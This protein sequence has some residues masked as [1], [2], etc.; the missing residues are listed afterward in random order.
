MLRALV[1]DRNLFN[2]CP[3]IPAA[4]AWTWIDGMLVVYAAAHCVFFDNLDTHACVLV[5]SAISLNSDDFSIG[6]NVN[7]GAFN[8]IVD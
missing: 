8:L 7:D 5:A 2:D 3:V 4:I 1:A 6:G